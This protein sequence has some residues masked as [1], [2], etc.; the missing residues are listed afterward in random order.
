MLQAYGEKF[1]SGASVTG[2]TLVSFAL[3]VRT[4]SF[5]VTD[6]LLKLSDRSFPP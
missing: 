6:V 5:L 3:M 1:M 4:R 2:L